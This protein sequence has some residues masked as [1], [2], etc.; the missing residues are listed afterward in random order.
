MFDIAAY[1]FYVVELI[2]HA[3]INHREHRGKV[4]RRQFYGYFCLIIDD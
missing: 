1:V 3:Y 2:I 4:S